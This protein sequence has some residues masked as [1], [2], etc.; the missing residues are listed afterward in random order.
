MPRRHYHKHA[1][2]ALERSIKYEEARVVNLPEASNVN[3]C[4]CLYIVSFPKQLMRC[5]HIFCHSCIVRCF[6]IFER[7][8]LCRGRS[9]FKE[10]KDVSEEYKEMLS[11]LKYRCIH[12][13]CN[14]AM[15]LPGIHY[16][17]LLC[18]NRPQIDVRNADANDDEYEWNSAILVNTY[19]KNGLVNSETH[20]KDISEAFFVKN[21][22]GHAADGND[23]EILVDV[24]EDTVDEDTA[25]EDTA[26][27]DT[28]DARND[29]VN[30][31]I[32]NDNANYVCRNPCVSGSSSDTDSFKSCTLELQNDGRLQAINA[33]S[34]CANMGNNENYRNKF[35]MV[36]QDN[37]I[38]RRR[39][40]NEAAL[41][42]SVRRVIAAL[43][44]QPNRPCD[45]WLR[46]HS[47][48]SLMRNPREQISL[49]SKAREQYMKMQ[50]LQQQRQ[51]EL[52]SFQQPATIHQLFASQQ[53]ATA[54]QPVA[55]SREIATTSH[56]STTDSQE[57]AS[58]SQNEEHA[59]GAVTTVSEISTSQSIAST[60]HNTSTSQQ[61]HSEQL[62]T[63]V[64]HQTP[65]TTSQQQSETAA[66][67]LQQL[68]TTPQQPELPGTTRTSE[69]LPSTARNNEATTFETTAD[70]WM[71][72]S[73]STNDL[74]PYN[75]KISRFG[76]ATSFLSNPIATELLVPT[77]ANFSDVFS[78]SFSDFF[79]F[80]S[81]G[82]SIPANSLFNFGNNR[83]GLNNS[84][85]PAANFRDFLINQFPLWNF[86]SNHTLN[87]DNNRPN[88]FNPDSPYHQHH[89]PPPPPNPSVP[90]PYFSNG[91]SDDFHLA[92]F[93]TE[94]EPQHS[95]TVIRD[96]A[97]S[98]RNNYMVPDMETPFLSEEILKE[99]FETILLSAH[100][101]LCDSE[102]WNQI[103][104]R[105][106]LPNSQ[107]D[108]LLYGKLWKEI[109]RQIE[110]CYHKVNEGFWSSLSEVN[111]LEICQLLSKKILKRWERLMTSKNRQ[112]KVQMRCHQAQHFGYIN[113]FGQFRI[114]G[115]R[116]EN[117]NF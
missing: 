13:G 88:L 4:L 109:I 42:A 28:A 53:T 68:E 116:S 85:P 35:V 56:E 47:F 95:L 98:M 70:A 79:N 10:I 72:P 74:N 80:H 76:T 55:A 71:E 73:T 6:R 66:A 22:T 59:N 43:F 108:V 82:V 7:C 9:S 69:Q 23:E 114:F 41:M 18:P 111:R 2:F 19:I 11:Q 91:I 14:I 24:D 102:L 27:E 113:F 97:R 33:A 38:D 93:P 64:Q 26:D 89:L 86:S 81:L 57:V 75:R 67:T 30:I 62:G 32:N 3:C 40:I 16:H 46:V 92:D 101:S 78:S 117:Y 37:A 12:P 63:N 90:N 110:N 103:I 77:A 96:P 94:D 25:D 115:S 49:T 8:P 39:A 65:P 51:F 84:N 52:E 21:G 31:E 17:Q 50:S 112:I 106:N 105:A 1:C 45:I 83:F 20:K 5:G 36:S 44:I 107:E 61:A 60:S 15:G 100:R 104:A 34:N 87:P 99:I 48:K 29:D 54:F 58:T